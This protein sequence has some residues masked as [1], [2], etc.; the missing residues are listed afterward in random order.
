MP[1]GDHLKTGSAAPNAQLYSTGSLKSLF[2]DAEPSVDALFNSRDPN[3]QIQHEKPEHRYLLWMKA[4]GASNREIATQSGYSESWLSQLFR[5]PWATE[6]LVEMLRESGKPVLDQTLSII[7][8]EAVN[9]VLKLVEIRDDPDTPKAVQRA[10]CVDIVE[11]F[12]G[13]PKQKVDVV[14]TSVRNIDEIDKELAELEQQEQFLRGNLT[15][16]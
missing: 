7:Q 1:S 12:L 9:S 15:K 14:Q 10:C 13:K 2:A 11:Q 5:Q 3:L 8:S 6:R 16:V 4:Q